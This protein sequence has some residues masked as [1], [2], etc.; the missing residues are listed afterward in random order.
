MAFVGRQVRFTVAGDELVI[1]LLLFY[2]DQL[3]Y[4]VVELKIG[5]FRT[6]T[7]RPARRLRRPR[8]RPPGS[9]VKRLEA[10]ARARGSFSRGPPHPRR[11]QCPEL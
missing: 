6:R 11:G 1:D 7:R 8:R 2:V 3:R 4:V 5:P 9:A 10:W